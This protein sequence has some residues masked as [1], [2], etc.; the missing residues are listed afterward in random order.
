[1]K[2][3]YN[4]GNEKHEAE[5]VSTTID[6]TSIVLTNQDK[7]LIDLESLGWKDGD[8]IVRKYVSRAEPNY[9]VFRNFGTTQNMVVS[10]W[11]RT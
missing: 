4:V 5:N 9:F 7:S 3:V 11:E 1:M 8:I 10:M 2:V 6:Q